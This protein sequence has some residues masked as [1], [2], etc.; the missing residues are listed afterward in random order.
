MIIVWI[1]YAIT[2]PVI[3]VPIGMLAEWIC[4]KLRR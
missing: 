4:R 3:S 1:L 2:P